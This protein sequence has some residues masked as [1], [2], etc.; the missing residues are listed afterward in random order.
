MLKTVCLVGAVLLLASPALAEISCG[1]TPIAP[2]IPTASAIAGKTAE[3]ATAAKHEAFVQVKAYQATLKTFRE[4]LITQT[5]ALKGTVD[6]A[7]DDA[8]KKAVTEKVEAMQK[9]YDKT[10]DDETQVV[11]DYG[12][13]QT[14]VCKIA[15]CAPPKK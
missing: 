9:V 14:A 10:I 11:S 15:E 8:A 2:A 7:K 12:A 5:T 13:L 6:A 4:C 1:T 3:E